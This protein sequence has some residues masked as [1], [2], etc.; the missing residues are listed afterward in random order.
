MRR[1]LLALV[2]G[3]FAGSAQATLF[4]RGSGFIYDDVL[5][6]TW[7]HPRLSNSNNWPDTVI[8]AESLSLYDS[9]RD[10]TWDDWRP[11]TTD[12]DGD[13]SSRDCA[14]APELFC[15]DN[16]LGY[17]YFHNGVTWANPEPFPGISNGVTYWGGADPFNPN[18][19]IR[20]W[21]RFNDGAQGQ[22]VESNLRW[23]W[24]VREGDVGVVPV[25]G[26]AWLFGSALGLLGWLRRRKAT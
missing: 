18:P 12:V 24:A 26:S 1:F 8:W 6:I 15:R 9:V 19:D 13:G 11:A 5:E 16:E 3:V 23:A 21:F 20:R 14:S 25:P 4:D 10:L 2:L 17:M 7:A 22:S